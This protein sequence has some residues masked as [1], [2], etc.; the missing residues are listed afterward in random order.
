[1]LGI[2][3]WREVH[4]TLD[5]DNEVLKELSFLQVTFR[6]QMSGWASQW[7]SKESATT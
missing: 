2:L 7:V 4:K 1:M 6:Y 3:A 5:S